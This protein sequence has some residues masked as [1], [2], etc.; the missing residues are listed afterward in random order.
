MGDKACRQGRSR[1]SACVKAHAGTYFGF[2]FAVALAGSVTIGDFGLNRFGT[3]RLRAAWRWAQPDWGR[4]CCVA[5][6]MQS[7]PRARAMGVAKAATA[8]PRPKRLHWPYG[9][10]RRP[11]SG[12]SEQGARWKSVAICWLQG[13][14]QAPQISARISTTSAGIFSGALISSRCSSPPRRRCQCCR[15]RRARRLRHRQ[16]FRYRC[17]S[18]C[19]SAALRPPA[20]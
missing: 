17:H 20:R 5:G 8:S 16:G 3:A 6:S 13:V 18:T 12:H 15:W 9:P 1:G 4:S 11:A 19:R 10:Q 7:I 2:G 14:G